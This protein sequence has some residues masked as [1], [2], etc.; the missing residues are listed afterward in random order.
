MILDNIIY[1]NKD[2]DYKLCCCIGPSECSDTNCKLVKEYKEK[3][4]ENNEK[5]N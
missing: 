3:Q 5:K 2:K 1:H 4:L